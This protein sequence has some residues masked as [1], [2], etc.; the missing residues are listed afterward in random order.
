MRTLGQS[1]LIVVR[2]TL[3]R[4]LMGMSNSERSLNSFLKRLGQ[5][6]RGLLF[7]EWSMQVWVLAEF[8]DSKG[9]G[10]HYHLC[11]SHLPFP[12]TALNCPLTNC[13]TVVKDSWFEE[14]VLVSLSCK[15]TLPNSAMSRDSANHISALPVWSSINLSL[16][17]AREENWNTGGGRWDLLLPVYFLFW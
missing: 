6:N 4:N 16:Q 5:T 3:I 13:R 9:E 12:F 11:S 2:D 15:F 14:S 8:L 17:G 1:T 7:V 10:Q